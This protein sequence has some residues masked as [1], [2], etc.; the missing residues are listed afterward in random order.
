MTSTRHS[1]RSP[2]SIVSFLSWG[3]SDQAE[4]GIRVPRYPLTVRG[5]PAIKTIMSWPDMA[6]AITR[7]F[8]CCQKARGGRPGQA[9]GHDEMIVFPV[10]SDLACRACFLALLAP[11]RDRE[12]GG[13]RATRQPGQVRK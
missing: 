9:P 1:G 10:V 3:C 13:G 8:D 7:S 2:M 6:R 11:N 12:I 5:G 4:S